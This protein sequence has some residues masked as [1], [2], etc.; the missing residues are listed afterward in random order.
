MKKVSLLVLICMLA[1]VVLM[2]FASCGEAEHTHLYGTD[3]VMDGTNHYHVCEC[4]AKNES[5]A[6]ADAD[7]DGACDTCKVIMAHNH[8]FDPAWTADATNHWHAVLCGHTVDVAN[9][10][11]HTPDAFGKCT[12]CGYKVSAPDATTVDKALV[13][14]TQAQSAVCGGKYS[15]VNPNFSANASFETSDGYIHIVSDGNH[16]YVT[17]N[18]DGTVCYVEGNANGFATVDKASTNTKYLAGPAMDLQNVAGV[19][20]TVYGAIELLTFFYEDYVAMAKEG[21]TAEVAKSVEDGVYAYSYAITIPSEWTDSGYTYTIAVAFTL[22]EENYFIDELTAVITGNMGTY[23]FTYDQWITPSSSHTPEDITPT[24]AVKFEYEGSVIEFVDGVASEEI[25]V[26]L[27]D[28]EYGLSS[29]KLDIS[30]FTS[31]NA[32]VEALGINIAFTD[33]EGGETYVASYTYDPVEKRISVKLD[34]LLASA[35]TIKMVITVGAET[36]TIPVAI[37]NADINGIQIN[38]FDDMMYNYVPTDVEIAYIGVDLLLVAATGEGTIQNEYTADVIDG[39]AYDVLTLAAND[40]KGEFEQYNKKTFVFNATVPGI[41]TVE[42]AS[43]IA[44]GVKDTVKIVVT[45]APTAAGTATGKWEIAAPGMSAVVNFYP[46]DVENT[47]GVALATLT[48]SRGMPETFIYTYYI[49]EGQFVATPYEMQPLVLSSLTI[50]NDWRVIL[51][52]GNQMT[53]SIVLKRTSAVADTWD[54]DFYGPAPEAPGYVDPNAPKVVVPGNQMNATEL[55]A[56]V[57]GT[58]IYTTTIE[59]STTGYFTLTNPYSTLTAANDSEWD[60]NWLITVVIDGEVTMTAP[61]AALN[62]APFNAAGSGDYGIRLA[63]ENAAT[64]AADATITVIVSELTTL[65]GSATASLAGGCDIYQAGTTVYTT[66]VAAGETV[67]FKVEDRME[68]DIE[69]LLDIAA[70]GEGFTMQIQDSDGAEVLN[71]TDITFNYAAYWQYYIGF[72]NT[73]DGEITITWTVTV[74]EVEA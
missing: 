11:A 56:P 21:T 66:T 24:E 19:E 40:G 34:N 68:N 67:W 58:Y 30:D 51:N 55:F 49:Y 16:I 27:G 48:P 22:D 17:K 15:L 26:T 69:Y 38:K 47:K 57:A 4:G 14:A 50:G 70:A 73:T 25:K 61:A 18:A 45:E 37:S 3:W 64:E 39:P 29:F 60:E 20:Q 52:E 23:T 71:A 54:E 43:T 44:E 10:A 31:A 6:H 59:G 9:K 72:T 2:A 63:L 62:N 28:V 46:Q 36:Y 12:V 33:S 65:T 74:T 1:S 13:L 41:Y 53:G 5:A 32:L 7:N 8:V 35:G 42:F